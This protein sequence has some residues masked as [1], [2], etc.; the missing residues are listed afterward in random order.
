MLLVVARGSTRVSDPRSVPNEV[1]PLPIT[2]SPGDIE[3]TI[4]PLLESADES[5]DDSSRRFNVTDS[6]FLFTCM[7]DDYHQ[8]LVSPLYLYTY[9]PFS[10]ASFNVSLASEPV[11]IDVHIALTIE[12]KGLD[13]GMIPDEAYLL[14]FTKL[15]WFLP[16]NVTVTNWDNVQAE[17]NI[18]WHVLMEASPCPTPWPHSPPGKQ[19]EWGGRKA[20]SHSSFDLKP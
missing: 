13:Q 20:T 3:F 2:T 18:T 14:T 6:T 11:D 19:S 1:S 7:D 5:Y 4:F 12:D 10:Q 17:G 8:I 15:N 9:E 16:Q